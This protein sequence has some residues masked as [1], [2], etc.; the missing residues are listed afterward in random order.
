MPKPPSSTFWQIIDTV[1]TVFSRAYMLA[2]ARAASLPSPVLRLIARRDHT[3]WEARM[4][5]RE[6]VSL[7]QSFGL[8]SNLI[9]APS[10]HQNNAWRSSRSCGFEAGRPS[11]RPIG[12]VLHL[13][14]L[15]SWTRALKN[16]KRGNRLFG[17][18]P[19]NKYHE[20][21]EMVGP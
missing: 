6:L 12:F 15:R 5:E 9:A 19:R 16:K 17:A 14:T 11:R 21:S 1:A 2:R 4:L 8:E 7:P 3:H 13:N 10:I 18:P 20:V